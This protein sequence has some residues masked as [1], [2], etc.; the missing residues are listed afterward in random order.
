[1]N[2]TSMIDIVFLLIIFFLVSSRLIQQEESVALRLPKAS[3]GE[4]QEQD[5]QRKEVFDVLDAGKIQLR[6]QPITVA[7]IQAYLQAKREQSDTE[8][9]VVIR[10]NRE[11]PS[12]E[13]KSII[14]A[15]AK[16]GVWNVSFATV[17]E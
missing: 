9:K 16:A 1:M 12:G 10:F 5:A 7:E 4:R 17:P 2:L 8:I 6:N 11:V 14:S 13:V 15:C 3:T